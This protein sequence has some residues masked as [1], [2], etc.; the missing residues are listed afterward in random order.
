MW[1]K[2]V[3]NFS[4]HSDNKRTQC[5]TCCISSLHSNNGQYLDSRSINEPSKLIWGM[6]FQTSYT[7][8]DA[9]PR[10]PGENK[11]KPFP[12]F[13]SAGRKNCTLPAPHLKAHKSCHSSARCI[14]WNETKSIS[15]IRP[16]RGGLECCRAAD[17]NAKL[18]VLKFGMR[19][20]LTRTALGPS[21]RSCA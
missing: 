15:Q 8:L 6:R 1:Q 7:R 11:K 10:R 19:M 20:H 12:P 14:I 2:H 5:F 21:D 16:L 13:I 3:Y 9:N 17:A 18:I 4:S